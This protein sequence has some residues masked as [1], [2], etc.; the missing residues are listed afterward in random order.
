MQAVQPWTVKSN[1]L[2]SKHMGNAVVVCCMGNFLVVC[3]MG[4]VVVMHAQCSRWLRDAYTKLEVL[5]SCMAPTMSHIT[6]AQHN[7]GVFGCLHTIAWTDMST[8]Q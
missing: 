8:H 1:L 7:L 4:N 6:Y 3:C 5:A 2:Y